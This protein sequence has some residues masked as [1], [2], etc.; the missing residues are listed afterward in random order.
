MRVRLGTV[1]IDRNGQPQIKRVLAERRFTIGGRE[2]HTFSFPAKPPYRVEIHVDKTFKPS[3]FGSSDARE[4]GAQ[5]A[6]RFV[7]TRR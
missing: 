4:L 3:D 7:R 5:V 2:V 6:H 1:R